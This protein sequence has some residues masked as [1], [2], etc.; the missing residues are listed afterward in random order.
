[1]RSHVSA[2]SVPEIRGNFWPPTRQIVC[3]HL[4]PYPPAT[5]PH[6][7]PLCLPRVWAL[8]V[9]SRRARLPLP[10]T[11]CSL[12]RATCNHRCARRPPTTPSRHARWA[13]PRPRIL[14]RALSTMPEATRH[15]AEDRVSPA[16]SVLLPLSPL[17]ERCGA[18]GCC[19]AAQR[20]T[21]LSEVLD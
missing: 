5:E 8:L 1:L 4:L 20:C 16:F 14:E 2:P 17:P 21:Y 6:S 11:V 13:S 19:S 18:G 10:P 12:H 7:P 15:E 9:S 3:L